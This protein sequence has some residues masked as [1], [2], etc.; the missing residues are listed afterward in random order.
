MMK[1][2]RHLVTL[3]CVLAVA[4]SAEAQT[5]TVLD[6][7]YVKETNLTK[8]VVPYPSLREADVMYV[9]RI[10]Q[11]I[12]LRQKI[13]QMFYFPVDP[14]E[15]RKNL[16]DVIRYALEVE[17]SLTA[18]GTGP[19]GDDDEFR[20]PY[21]GTQVDS[22]LNPV[23]II[24]QFDPVTGEVIGSMEAQTSINSQDIVRYRVK[25][26]WVWD[27]Q[28]SQRQVRIIGIAP[29]IEKK[30]DE[31]NSQGLAPLFWLYYPECR[32]VFANAECY[33]YEND[34]QRRTF[35]EIFQKRYF[36][37]YIVKETNVFDRSIADY[38]QG[39]DALLE[40]E[41]IKDELFTIEHDLWHY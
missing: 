11:D 22:V 38:A 29:I 26:D 35:E 27:R 5:Q 34:A 10:W 20:Y 21:T 13:N 6:G 12:D 19:A 32:Y 28:R 1:A 37:S 9:R 4:L 31:G 18:Y 36:S 33:N 40:S 16:F 30:D 14:I 25:E 17:G 39:L 23:V 7:A 24:P 15:D 41:R 2:A 3:L 8:R